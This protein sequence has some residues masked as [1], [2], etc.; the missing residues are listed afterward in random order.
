MA[1]PKRLKTD[2]RYRPTHNPEAEV[3]DNDYKIIMM[4][5]FKAI[6]VRNGIF[7][8]ISINRC[9]SHQRLQP[10][11]VSQ[12]AR[13]LRAEKN[14]WHLA[15]TPCGEPWGNLGCVR[16]LASDS[17]GAYQ[18]NDSSDPIHRKALNSLTWDIWFSLINN[19]LWRS[20][21]PG[22]CCKTPIYPGFSPRLL[23]AV[24]QSYLKRCLLG[25]SPHLAPD[26]T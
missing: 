12:W 7:P 9:H 14:T 2:N 20:W 1:K 15:A 3:T 6:D 5:S 22:L 19:N 21:L 24:S 10:S 4:D 11:N 13:K 26:K 17:W 18:R 25:C 23:G 16:I 8:A